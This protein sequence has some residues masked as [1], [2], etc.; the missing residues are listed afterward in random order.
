M[1]TQSLD[2]PL[3]IV[4]LSVRTSEKTA[5]ADIGALWQKAGAG[6]HLAFDA[7]NYGVYFSYESDHHGEYDVLV[8]RESN[9]PLKEGQSEIVIPAGEYLHLADEGAIP[10]TVIKLWQR[11]YAEVEPQRA[12]TIDFERY[13]GSPQHSTVEL[14]IAAK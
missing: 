2:K 14:F 12:Y 9:E 7:P 10:D 11:V 5:P 13:V 3:R 8:G 4:G 6:G 1:G